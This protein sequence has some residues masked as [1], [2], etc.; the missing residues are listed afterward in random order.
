MVP[1]DPA[2]VPVAATL[3]ERIRMLE[4]E[5]VDWEPD[6]AVVI[7]NWRMLHGRSSSI[8]PDAGVRRLQRVVIAGAPA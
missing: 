4:P 1:A 7:D 6:L 2:F 8:V 5:V 3:S